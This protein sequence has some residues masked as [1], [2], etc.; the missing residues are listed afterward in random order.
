MLATEYVI[1]F[2]KSTRIIIYILAILV[3]LLAV[4]QKCNVWGL[5]IFIAS[6]IAS[7]R[8]CK[9]SNLKWY[10][11]VIIFIIIL[12]YFT[13]LSNISKLNSPNVIPTPFNQRGIVPPINVPF[14]HKYGDI[15]VETNKNG[16]SK[17]LIKIIAFN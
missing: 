17:F 9:F 13:A 6:I 15:F 2:M 3:A 4:I 8:G 16:E 7:L 11:L 5:L 1:K 12:E 14:Y 10:N